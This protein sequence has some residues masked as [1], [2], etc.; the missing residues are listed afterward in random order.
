MRRSVKASIQCR[1]TG[2][3]QSISRCVNQ[4][5]TRTSG[6]PSPAVANAMRTPS[7][8]VQNWIRCF[9]GPSSILSVPRFVPAQPRGCRE[10]L[11]FFDFG[12]L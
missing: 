7:R 10:S 3:S 2:L 12:A 8:D 1:Q 11:L 4:L 9:I 5:V 6:G